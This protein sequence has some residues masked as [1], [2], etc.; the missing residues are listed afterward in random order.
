V[1][2]LHQHT[3]QSVAQRTL[4]LA[5]QLAEPGLWLLVEERHQRYRREPV[6]HERLEPREAMASTVEEAARVHTVAIGQVSPKLSK[7]WRKF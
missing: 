4:E 7:E 5:D 3:P 1:P 2:P 6:D